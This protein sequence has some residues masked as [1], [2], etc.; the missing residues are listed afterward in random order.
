[1]MKLKGLVKKWPCVIEVLALHLL[2]ETGVN[3]NALGRIIYVLAKICTKHRSLEHY[4][5]ANL[6]SPSAIIMR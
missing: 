1:M 2:G 4:S 3:H 6:F 5:Y